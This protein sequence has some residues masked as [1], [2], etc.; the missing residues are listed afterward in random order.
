MR[1]HTII[2]DAKLS[3]ISQTAK[4]TKKKFLIQYSEVGQRHAPGFARLSSAKY[5]QRAKK[6][7]ITNQIDA[8][9]ANPKFSIVNFQL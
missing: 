9:P 6:G 2:H 4:K 5:E 7:Q 8:E 3:I 1:A